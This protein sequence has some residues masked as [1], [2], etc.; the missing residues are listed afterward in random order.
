[1]SKQ[2]TQKVRFAPGTSSSSSSSIADQHATHG[3][4]P[5]ESDSTELERYVETAIYSL[6]SDM[7]EEKLIGLLVAARYVIP[8]MESQTQTPK[9]DSNEQISQYRIRL[10]HA[11]TPQFLQE[12]LVPLETG[13]VLAQTEGELGPTQLAKLA[14][15]MIGFFAREN[16]LIGLCCE[17]LPDLNRAAKSLVY[18]LKESDDENLSM[19]RHHVDTLIELSSLNQDVWEQFVHHGDNFEVRRREQNKQ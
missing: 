12:L 9:D 19:Q 11:T 5:T 8:T 17:L 1:M 4:N 6:E 14:L 2:Q 3:G 13:V 15:V 16:E 7:T 10:F 18:L